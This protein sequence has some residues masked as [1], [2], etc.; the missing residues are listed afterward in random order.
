LCISGHFPRVLNEE[1][2]EAQF[3]G[4]QEYR[5]K[6]VMANPAVQRRTRGELLDGQILA[7]QTDG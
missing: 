7:H 5:L 6:F 4:M 3:L 2:S 1:I